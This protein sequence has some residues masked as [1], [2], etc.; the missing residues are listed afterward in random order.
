MSN[1]NHHLNLKTFITWLIGCV[2]R[3]RRSCHFLVPAPSAEQQRLV[4]S[5]SG[6][7]QHSEQK[8]LSVLGPLG[9]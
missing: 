5:N 7:L 2:L 9:A 8:D 3:H 6:G 4:G 1:V